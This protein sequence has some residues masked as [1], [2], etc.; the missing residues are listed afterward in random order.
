ML[1]RAKQLNPRAVVVA[2][3]CYVQTGRED[4]EKDGSVDLCIGYVVRH[5]VIKEVN[6]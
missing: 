1:H 2:V 6:R 5:E 3:G 4:L